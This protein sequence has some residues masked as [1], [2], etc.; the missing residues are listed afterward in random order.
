MNFI[1]LFIYVLILSYPL[2]KKKYELFSPISMWAILTLFYSAPFLYIAF[3]TREL[4]SEIV[5]SNTGFTYNHELR[6]FMFNQSLFAICYFIAYDRI[7]LKNKKNLFWS[8]PVSKSICLTSCLILY[9]IGL[10]LVIFFILSFGGLAELILA[11]SVNKSSIT[12]GN[13]I[14]L[15]FSS[16]FIYLGAIFHIKHLSYCKQRTIGLILC[17]L[18]GF[19]VLS[20][21]GGRGP[22]LT[23]TLTVG[24][25][26]TYFIKPIKVVSVKL[27]PVYVGLVAFFVGMSGLRYGND[28]M[29]D[30]LA[31]NSLSIFSGNS[32]VDIQVGIQDYFDN[33]D[34]WWGKTFANFHEAFIPRSLYPNKRPVD[35]GV[36]YFTAIY[37]GGPVFDQKEY[38]NSWPPGTLGSMYANFGYLGIIIGAFLLAYLHKF[39]YSLFI[40]N[41]NN[42]LFVYVYSFV[43]IK[44]Q[45]T[46]YYFANLA[47]HIIYL[48]LF[49]MIFKFLTPKRKVPR[50]MNA[51]NAKGGKL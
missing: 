36:Y 43:A 44:F 8:V 11:F 34:H 27:L 39:I 7:H 33:H 14:Y 35:E 3:T 48:I 45:L 37:E 4:S 25:C 6:M 13:Q 16:F 12:D 31:E 26:Y 51:T 30:I 32:Y 50:L 10:S 18:F 21:A 9:G 24:M 20:V 40:G 46:F 5:L 42:I 38:I 49:L 23:Y 15:S 1:L 17:L 28:D 47:Y 2:V 41:K 22:F 29:G 19:V